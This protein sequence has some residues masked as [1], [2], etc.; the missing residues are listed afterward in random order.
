MQKLSYEFSKVSSTLR[1][2]RIFG[3]FSVQMNHTN[4]VRGEKR[5]ITNRWTKTKQIVTYIQ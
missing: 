1:S 3:E 4:I 2:F 5:K